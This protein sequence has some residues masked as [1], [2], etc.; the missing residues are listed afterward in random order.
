M[1]FLRHITARSRMEARQEQNLQLKG[2]K[3]EPRR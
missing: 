3:E 1:F 2:L